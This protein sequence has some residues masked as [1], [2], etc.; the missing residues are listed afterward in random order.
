MSKPVKSEPSKRA[1]AAKARPRDDAPKPSAKPSAAKK[2]AKAPKAEPYPDFL[3][4]S[5]D[6][7]IKATAALAAAHGEP[8]PPPR[9][10]VIN[11]LVRTILSQNTTD[12]TSLVAFERLKAGLP[13]WRGVLDAAP[14]VA[15]ELV[16]CGGLAD[17]KMERV[18]AILN[19]PRVRGAPDAE[20]S[21]EWL[22]GVD[23]AE[24]KAVLTSFKGVGPKTVSC[25]MMFELGRPE[26]PV[27]THVLHIAKLL[28]WIPAA[29]SREAA[30]EHLNRRVPDEVKFVLHVLLVEHGKTN[31]RCAKNGK[32]QK[33]EA[34]VPV[35]PLHEL[36]MY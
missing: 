15:E 30:Y 20:P 19:D 13:T 6:D 33:P 11:S 5:A 26:F 25:V 16:R 21:L 12:R 9:K 32:L 18:R 27:D 10:G 24:A 2:R 35:C 8:K 7:A 34:E 14:G 23:D 3:A 1:T 28:K 36:G 17:V 22:R 29:A 4:P 31:R